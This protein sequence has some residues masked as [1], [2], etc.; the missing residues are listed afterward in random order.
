MK[1]KKT[2]NNNSTTH[3]LPGTMDSDLSSEFS[4][5][6]ELTAEEQWEES[7][8][9]IEGLINMVIF[10]LIGKVLGRRVSKM[11]WYKINS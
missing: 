2:N 5:S 6:S 9:Q 7:I 4:E 8:K 1:K 11:I 10:P 3:P